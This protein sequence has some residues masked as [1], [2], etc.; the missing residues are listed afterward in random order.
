M[1]GDHAPSEI[2]KGAYLAINEYNISIILVGNTDVLSE[3]DTQHP[4]VSVVHASES[5]DMDEPPLQ[6]YKKKKTPPFM[7]GYSW[8]RMAKLMLFYRQGTREQLCHVHYLFWVAFL[9]LTARP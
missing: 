7:L 8:L 9:V 6:A 5:I 2:I 1:G 4:N 3:F